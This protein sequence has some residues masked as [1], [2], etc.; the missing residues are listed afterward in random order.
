[1][2][3]W[4]RI[5]NSRV[6]AMDDW[7]YFGPPEVNDQNFGLVKDNP[8]Y[9][10]LVAEIRQQVAEEHRRMVRESTITTILF[11]MAVV[12]FIAFVLGV[13]SGLRQA[14]ELDRQSATSHE[15]PQ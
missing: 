3:A 5:S 4:N 10:H 11:A 8:R 9:K 6:S 13:G 7:D 12:A 14:A 15:E 1:M 2:V